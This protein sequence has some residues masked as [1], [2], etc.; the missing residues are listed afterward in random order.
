[1]KTIYL[2][3]LAACTNIVL[4]DCS[5]SKLLDELES[6]RF[7]EIN[8]SNFSEIKCEGDASLV[9]TEG[10]S[11]IGYLMNGKLAYAQAIYLGDS[12]K[13]HAFVKIKEG[14]VQLV[15]SL[16]YRYRMPL[17]LSPDQA[18]EKTE[19]F[20]LIIKSG[21]VMFQS[22][23]DTESAKRFA[24]QIQQSISLLNKAKKSQGAKGQNYGRAKNDP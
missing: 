5:Q 17:M 4:A 12:I 2:L 20:R 10:A 19:I 7:Q 15:N 11:V 16:I 13:I 1:M 8:L 14:D 9:T 3:L 6:F 24:A 23:K 21:R 18:P 22:D